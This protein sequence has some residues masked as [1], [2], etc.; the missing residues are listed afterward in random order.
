MVGKKT[1]ARTHNYTRGKPTRWYGIMGG[2]F[3]HPHLLSADVKSDERK[4]KKKIACIT[5]IFLC[6]SSPF[7]SPFLSRQA[8]GASH[9]MLH[10]V[11][12]YCLVT[13]CC[14]FS[15]IG[16]WQSVSFI[17]I[18]IMAVW[19]TMAVPLVSFYSSSQFSY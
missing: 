7:H 18:I 1:K 5:L 19:M 12:V 16:R 14:L 10:I 9:R 13:S 6:G 2:H 15:G 3:Q 8:S 11:R 4:Q 17:K